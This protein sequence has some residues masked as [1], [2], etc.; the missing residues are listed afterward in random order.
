MVIPFATRKAPKVTFYTVCSSEPVGVKPFLSHNPTALSLG[1][2]V[3][4]KAG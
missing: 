1:I 2:A 3:A 4:R